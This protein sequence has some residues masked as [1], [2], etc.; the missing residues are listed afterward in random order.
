MSVF[1]G[2]GGEVEEHLH[3]DCWLISL[4][5][6]GWRFWH[7]WKNANSIAGP[8]LHV[9]MQSIDNKPHG[10]KAPFPPLYIYIYILI[11]F[12]FFVF[13]GE[14][15]PSW[16]S[17]AFWFEAVAARRPVWHCAALRNDNYYW[18]TKFLSHRATDII[19]AV[20]SQLEFPLRLL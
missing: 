20:V 1:N 8:A 4:S 9:L 17:M 3:R 13:L 6:L 10:N 14:G 12:N 11:L 7:T 16:Y 2:E 18:F 19:R 15:Y 5:S